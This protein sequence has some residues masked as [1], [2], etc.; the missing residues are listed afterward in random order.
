[1][2]KTKFYVATLAAAVERASR[3][4]PNKGVAFDKAAG[5]VLEVDPTEGVAA[6]RSTDLEVYYREEIKDVVEYGDEPAMWRLPSH[7]FAGIIAG[8]PLDKEV[9]IKDDGE[10]Q[11]RIFCG[12]KQAKLRTMPNDTY[13]EWER[14]PKDGLKEV[15]GFA[16]RVNQVA[17]A[18]DRDNV[19]FTGVHID[20]THLNATDRYRLARVPCE[21][22]LD[23]PVTVAVSTLAPILKNLPGEVMLAADHPNL[24]VRVGDEVEARCVL[25]EKKYPDLKRA[26]RDDF[27][28]TVKVHRETLMDAI[29][30]MLVLVK[31]ERYPRMNFD[32]EEGSISLFMTVPETGDMTDIVE[33][34]FE[35]D[36]LFSIDFTPEFLVK[37]LE[38]ANAEYVTWSLGPDRKAMT[39]FTD[40]DY[41]AYV[42]PLAEAAPSTKSA[43]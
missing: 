32:F 26:L 20:G 6:L 36:G 3:I 2:A 29:Q 27:S 30:A 31:N 35:H 42:M 4:A 25:L 24:L 34:E 33:A 8:L 11:V 21:V 38:A 15:P 17:W 40:G 18:V 16:H 37:A 12:R 28:L 10:R 13:P 1:M 9:T 5:I 43:A 41:I 39:S 7:L 23:E 19:P 14:V 22:P